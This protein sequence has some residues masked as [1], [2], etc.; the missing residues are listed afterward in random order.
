MTGT[1]VDVLNRLAGICLPP[2][3]ACMQVARK[4]GHKDLAKRIIE[5]EDARRQQQ[6]DAHRY[7]ND[8]E[9]AAH[10]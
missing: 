6:I 5:L 7:H 2:M 3:R 10:M 4:A 9:T 1:P 8:L